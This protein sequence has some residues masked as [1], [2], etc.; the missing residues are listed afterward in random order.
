MTPGGK[1]ANQHENEHDDENGAKH[2]SVLVSDLD[3]SGPATGGRRGRTL[4]QLDPP[5]RGAILAVPN[6]FSNC[7]STN[8]YRFFSMG[9]HSPLGFGL[10]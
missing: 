10:D 1:H 5:F 7:P 6:I 3:L 8:F 2:E 9:H 4:R